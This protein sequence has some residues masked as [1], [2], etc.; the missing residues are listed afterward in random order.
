M[1]AASRRAIE[2]ASRLAVL[3]LVPAHATRP[4]GSTTTAHMAPTR[5]SSIGR[6]TAPN[7]QSPVSQKQPLKEA[8]SPMPRAL[9]TRY[10]TSIHTSCHIRRRL[11]QWPL[12]TRIVRSGL[13]SQISGPE[14]TPLN[15]IHTLR[16]R[17]KNPVHRLLVQP[18]LRETFPGKRVPVAGIHR[19]RRRRRPIDDALESKC[20]DTLANCMPKDKK[21]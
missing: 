9:K 16:V 17:R 5:R 1:S 12:H 10:V 19:P 20:L 4:T 11:I 18:E 13:R 15:C 7:I 8:S 14:K 2:A 6:S 21:K 3:E